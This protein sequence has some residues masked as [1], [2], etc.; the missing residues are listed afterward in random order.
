[1]RFERA[2]PT[3][4][5]QGSGNQL[6]GALEPVVGNASP[7]LRAA[8]TYEGG[9]TIRTGCITPY[10]GQR[11]H[12]VAHMLRAGPLNKVRAEPLHRALLAIALWL[13]S[14]RRY[15]VGVSP[16][17]SVPKGG[18]H[19][20]VRLMTCVGIQVLY[21]EVEVASVDSFQGR[22]KDYIIL[23]CVR[24]NEHQGIGFLNDPRRLNV[25]LTRA[26]YGVVVL[27]NP[28]ARP[29]LPCLALP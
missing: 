5:I 1:V 10:E 16:S 3:Q 14:V 19:P 22:E 13:P 8:P 24:S 28:K 26:K 29:P 11:A 15:S 9:T 17:L 7:A 4:G 18:L 25:A 6:T 20:S 27:G 2:S 21:R 23:S 12:V